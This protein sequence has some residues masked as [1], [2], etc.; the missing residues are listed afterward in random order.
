MKRYRVLIVVM[1]MVMSL[2]SLYAQEHKRVEVTKNYTHEASP[3]KKMVAPT[4]ISDAPV[5]EPEISYSVSPETWQIELEDHN[6]NPATASYWDNNRGERL[7]SRIAVGYPLVTDFAVRYA[8]HNVRLG[9]FGVGV[10][11]DGNFAMR[12]NGLGIKQSIANSF[13]MSNRVDVSGGL[14]VGRQMLE[15]RVDYDNSIL[16]RYAKATPDRLAFN[17][18]DVSVRYGD[19]FVDLSRINFGVEVDGGYW[20]G[21]I[22]AVGD[23]MLGEFN[24]NAGLNFARNFHGNVVG[25]EAGFGL[26]KGDAASRYRDVAFN[27]GVNYGRSFGVVDLKAEVQYMHDKV[28]DN[29][30][31][32]Y[33]MPAL[34]VDFNL[35]KVAIVPFIEFSTNIKHNNIESLYEANPFIDHAAMQSIFRTTAS[36]RSYDLH[37]GIMGAD[38]ASKL[39][40][41]VYLG[42]SFIADQMLWYVSELGTFGFAQGNNNRLFVGAELE[43]QPVGGLRLAASARAHMD[44]TNSIYAVSDAKIVAG[45]LAEYCLQRWKFNLS[46]DFRSKRSWSGVA[47]VEG[48]APMAFTAPAC[49]DLKANIA[50]KVTSSIEAY[51]EGYNLL[52]QP[53]FDYAHYYQN[54]IGFM[55]GVKID[56]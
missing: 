47:N 33:F 28:S 35:D 37:Y 4:Q 16:N 23:A 24:A 20:N 13:A 18:A 29:R 9:Y 50:F 17:D 44:R 6:F 25:F 11:H 15:A 36:T 22:P 8:T 46:G 1:A 30:G 54:G 5:I 10:E 39:A 42:S 43:Y 38:R 21:G 40:Y 45:V 2:H 7:F 53:I 27:V 26:W 48:V 41:R 19:D 55:L 34:C 49:F 31:R 52:N 12:E 3:A 56:F 32:S 51:A 14:V